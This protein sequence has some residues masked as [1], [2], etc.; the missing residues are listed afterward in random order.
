MMMQYAEKPELGRIRLRSTEATSS[1]Q[2]PCASLQPRVSRLLLCQ[3]A[4]TTLPGACSAVHIG[5]LRADV[6]ANNWATQRS[7]LRAGP[8]LS[9]ARVRPSLGSRPE[10]E[11]KTAN[12]DRAQNRPRF[13][14]HRVECG[15]LKLNIG[16][17]GVW[18]SRAGV[19]PGSAEFDPPPCCMWPKSPRSSAMPIDAWRHR[20]ASTESAQASFRNHLRQSPPT[21]APAAR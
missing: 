19:G 4:P 11:R 21:R 7:T 9:H 14:R 18:W 20:P 6:Q 2:S 13:G 15:G 17:L 16:E 1:P 12:F 3:A 8:N 5:T 10:F